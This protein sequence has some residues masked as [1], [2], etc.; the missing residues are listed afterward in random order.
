VRGDP[1]SE[2]NFAP[3]AFSNPQ[4]GHAAMGRVYEGGPM[5]STV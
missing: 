1:H 5:R 4:E 3:V 2:Q